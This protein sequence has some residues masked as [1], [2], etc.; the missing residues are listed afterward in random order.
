M[1]KTAFSLQSSRSSSSQTWCSRILWE[2]AVQMLPRVSVGIEDLDDN[3]TDFAQAFGASLRTPATSPSENHLPTNHTNC[4]G[5]VAVTTSNL[6]TFQVKTSGSFA[7]SNL[8]IPHVS[9]AYSNFRPAGQHSTNSLSNP[10]S[11]SAHEERSSSF[12]DDQRI[13]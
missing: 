13:G 9:C 5:A 10:S 3:I 7:V 11:A 12:F 4:E 1:T 2:R 8:A 6:E